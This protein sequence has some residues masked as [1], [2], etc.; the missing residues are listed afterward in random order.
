V[1]TDLGL[2]PQRI[3]SDPKVAYTPAQLAE[4]GAI[5]LKWNQIEAHLDFIGSHILFAKTPFWL[6]MATSDTLN[7]NTKLGLLKECLKSPNFLDDKAVNCIADCFA[8]ID[9]CRGYR[10]A[11][12]HH[13]IYEHEKG[14]GSFVD[15]SEKAFQIL[16]SIDALTVLYN[17]MCALLLEVREIDLLFRIEMDAQRPGRLDEKTGVFRLFDDAYLKATIIPEQT[18]RILKLQVD[19]KKLQKLP[20]FPDADIIRSLNKRENG[21]V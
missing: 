21:E 11:I 2:L 4:I 5:A 19:R 14:I 3:E 8:K 12:I 9:E 15:Q 16:V 13:H 6:R 1:P 18:K 20:Q 17:F 7:S 10:N